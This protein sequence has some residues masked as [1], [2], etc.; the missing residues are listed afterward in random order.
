MKEWF[1]SWFNTEYYHI[2]YENHDYSEAENFIRN[3]VFKLPIRS[4]DSVLD[5]ACGRGRHSI[6]LSSLG[7]KTTGIDLS[8]KNI[9][10]A[11]KYKTGNLDFFVHDMREPLN[12]LHFDVVLNLFTSFGYFRS[13]ENL[14]ILNAI[15]SYLRPKGKLV[16]DFLNSAAIKEMQEI[17]LSK[18]VNDIDFKIHKRV[19]GDQIIKSIRFEIDGKLNQYEERVSLLELG[20]FE[21]LFETT[22]FKID[23]VFGNYNFE[24]YQKDSDR[25]ILVAIKK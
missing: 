7:V 9:S 17:D 3:L 5:L 13:E 15:H 1:E 11:A 8:P 2:L 14:Q 24:E 22:N 16:I 21:D 18:S 10:K 20:D 19:E 25:L 12:G 4:T 23:A 6:Y